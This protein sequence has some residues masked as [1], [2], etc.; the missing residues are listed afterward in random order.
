[1]TRR[2]A[3]PATAVMVTAAMFSAAAI[4]L[5]WQAPADVVI[6]AAEGNLM[7]FWGALVGAVVDLISALFRYV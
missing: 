2:L 4:S 7:P 5:V 3:A 6:A 1:M